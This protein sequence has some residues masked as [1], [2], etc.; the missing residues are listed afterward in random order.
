MRII[1]TAFVSK[2][3]ILKIEKFLERKIEK[4]IAL[5]KAL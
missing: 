4:S 5:F 1:V 2:K 3:D